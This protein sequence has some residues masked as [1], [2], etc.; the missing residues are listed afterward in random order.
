MELVPLR[1]TQVL[2]T[3][4]AQIAVCKRHHSV[5]RHLCRWLVRSLRRLSFQQM[6]AQEF[7]ATMLGVR[8]DV[9]KAPGKL[10]ELGIIRYADGQITAVYRPTLKQVSCECYAVIKNRGRQL[11]SFP[12][13]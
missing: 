13:G 11:P 5:D 1:Y 10:Q 2:M 6:M 7:I 4:M 12:H 8:R 3:K 9:T